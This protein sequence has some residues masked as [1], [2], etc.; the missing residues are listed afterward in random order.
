MNNITLN[1]S[2]QKGGDPNKHPSKKELIH[3][4]PP[5]KELIHE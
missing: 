1:E 4:N 3:M 2:T 5:K